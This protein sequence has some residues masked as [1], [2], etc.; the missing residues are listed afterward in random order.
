MFERFK[1]KIITIEG[2]DGTGKDTVCN[3]LQENLPNSVVVRFP[4]RANPS[5][6]VIDAILRKQKPME[7]LSFQS[8][9][10]I[11]KVETLKNIERSSAISDPDYFIFCRYTPSAYVYGM[12]D[13]LPLEYSQDI[14]SVLPESWMTIILHGKN[15]GKHDEYYEQDD[16]QSKISQSYLNLAKKFGWTVLRN[17]HKP[18]EIVSMILD[19]INIRESQI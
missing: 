16:A 5:G 2:A 10:V 3:L 14:N 19:A 1:N 13:G 6:Q 15:Y 17:H 9:Q 7:S 4:N 8:L 12:N 18:Q 11:N